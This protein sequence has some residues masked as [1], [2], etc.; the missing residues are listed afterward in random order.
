MAQFTLR[1]CEQN[2]NLKT[3]PGS[4]RIKV[5][6]ATGPEFFFDPDGDRYLDATCASDFDPQSLGLDRERLSQELR[7][8]D[9]QR[10]R[11]LQNTKAEKWEPGERATLFVSGQLTTPLRERVN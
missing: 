10:R 6:V 3:V 1:F 2:L 9:K 11:E 8:V 7:K 5:H 4:A